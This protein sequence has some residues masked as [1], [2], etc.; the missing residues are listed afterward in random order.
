[1][2]DVQRAGLELVVLPPKYDDARRLRLHSR[3]PPALEKMARAIKRRRGAQNILP[4]RV[5]TA[6]SF[7]EVFAVANARV[8]ESMYIWLDRSPADALFLALAVPSLEW[9]TTFCPTTI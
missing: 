2:P 6:P 8:Y 7:S 9:N 5:R 1:V 4:I 3:G